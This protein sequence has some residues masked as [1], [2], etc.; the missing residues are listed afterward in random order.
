MESP[1]L[2]LCMHWD[3]ESGRWVRRRDSVLDCGSPLPLLRLHTKSKSARGL[4]Q[5][6]TWRPFGRFTERTSG[7]PI[8]PC[9]AS[10]FDQRETQPRDARAPARKKQFPCLT[11]AARATIF[12][13]HFC[14]IGSS[15][16]TDAMVKSKARKR[17]SKVGAKKS[18]KAASKI[19]KKS[20]AKAQPKSP[21]VKSP[22]VASSPSAGVAEASAKLAANGQ[23]RSVN[24]Q[25]RAAPLSAAEAI[26]TIKSQSGFDLTEKIKE[27]V[28][29]A[30]EQGYLTYNDINDALPDTMITPEELDEI[31]IKLRN[32]EV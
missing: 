22:T 12:H 23:S 15:F 17:L 8:T 5:S 29:L 30:Q 13:G 20:A 10:R 28:R 2:Y 21:T 32:L 1:F 16:C 19:A 7:A 27:L 18:G 11:K 4:A 31:Y 6:K 24:L 9:G 26:G 14:Y 3:R 25:T